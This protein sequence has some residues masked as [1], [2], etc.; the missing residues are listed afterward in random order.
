MKDK[1]LLP[2]LLK[3]RIINTIHYGKLYDNKLDNLKEI[4]VFL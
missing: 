1:T 3:A 4:N 2:M